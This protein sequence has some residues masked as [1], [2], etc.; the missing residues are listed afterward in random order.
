MVHCEAPPPAV[1]S[2]CRA[3][4]TSTTWSTRA[5]AH[6]LSYATAG[7]TTVGPDEL[8]MDPSVHQKIWERIKG[9][10]S[11]AMGGET[12]VYRSVPE[13]LQLF[14]AP[15]LVAAIDAILG[16]GWAFVPY[17]HSH[18]GGSGHGDQ[19]FHKDDNAPYNGRRMR[20]H[21]PCQLEIFYYPQDVTLHNGPTAIIPFSNYWTTDHEGGSDGFS[22]GACARASVCSHGSHSFLSYKTDESS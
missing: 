10:A 13:F 21:R 17:I 4:T 19:H 11:L 9:G 16:R 8:Q 2:Q 20:H 22:A 1:V 7:F 14:R 15:A 3:A 6:A 18:F 5:E 12:A